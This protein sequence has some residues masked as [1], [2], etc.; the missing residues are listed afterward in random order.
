MEILTW[1]EK[2]V[3]PSISVDGER[4]GASVGEKMTDNS[5]RSIAVKVIHVSAFHVFVFPL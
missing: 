2:Y 4:Q 5:E 1:T 3:I